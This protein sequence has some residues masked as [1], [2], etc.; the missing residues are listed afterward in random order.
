MK[1]ILINPRYPFYRGK[2]LFPI[3]LG[4]I[5]A[6]SERCGCETKVLDM[7]VDTK[8]DLKHTVEQFKPDIVGITC[9]SPVFDE[10]KKLT[11][12]IK[13]ISSAKIIIGGVHATFRPDECLEIADIVVRGEGEQTFEDILKGNKQEDIAGIS[14]KHDGKIV[15]NP[16]REFMSDLDSIPS[17]AYHLFPMKKYRIHS[18]I[19]SRGCPF[20]CIYCCSTNFWKNKVRYRSIDKFFDELKM[21][22]DKHGTRTLKI[23]DSTFT[24][25]KERVLEFCKRMIETKLD[26]FWSCETRPDTL[27][28]EMLEKMKQAGCILL[29]IGV[30]S[31]AESVLKKANRNMKTENIEMIFKK[32][33]ELGIRTRAYITFGLPSENRESVEETID[34]LRKIRADQVM[35]SLA[36]RYPGTKLDERLAITR[37]GK[38]I[39][40]HPDWLG[41]FEGHDARFT[42][43]YIP[44]GMHKKKYQELADLMM[45]E[46]KRIEKN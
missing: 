46:I 42:D 35:L 38:K 34:L 27:D 31:A 44:E 43:L 32:A 33:N 12:Q 29:C 14:F 4:Y 28:N 5:A 21:L 40:F 8:I 22:V 20:S 19:S 7:N 15:H 2:D 41:K 45:M 39:S 37:A 23:H 24:I 16:D 6:I 25:N 18:A 17:P 10:V 36:T 26:L 13:L 30:D 3:G 1:L 9:T 11:K